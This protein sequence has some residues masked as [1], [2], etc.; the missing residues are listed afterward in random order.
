[1]KHHLF[2]SLVA[3]ILL[4]PLSLQADTKGILQ[5]QKPEEAQDV[6]AHEEAIQ[7]EEELLNDYA[8]ALLS[9][10]NFMEYVTEAEHFTI[11]AR[12]YLTVT[13]R[14]LSQRY[15]ILGSL[16]QLLSGIDRYLAD[17]S[18]RE[19]TAQAAQ[20][21]AALQRIEQEMRTYKQKFKDGT[22][23]ARERQRVRLL[24]QQY[25]LESSR[26]NLLASRLAGKQA[27]AEALVKFREDLRAFREGVDGVLTALHGHR[28]AVAMVAADVQRELAF[29]VENGSQLAQFQDLPQK[30]AEV[31]PLTHDLEERTRNVTE[32]VP[33]LGT[34]LPDITE[35]F[36][37]ESPTDDDLAALFENF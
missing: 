16:D 37:M 26:R 13:D 6:F 23:S 1:M 32:A 27:S 8:A 30:L 35:Q 24:R 21:S 20:A 14:L 2:F 11:Q 4:I 7:L 12:R 36:G 17:A 5:L 31:F 33:H 19:L 9:S 18:Q 28:S 10:K 29:L 3:A 15:Q 22:L 25:Q 34:L